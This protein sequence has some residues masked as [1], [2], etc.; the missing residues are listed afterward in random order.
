MLNGARRAA[1][2]SDNPLIVNG[3][4][5]LANMELAQNKVKWADS[6]SRLIN[7]YGQ[8]VERSR[9]L[10]ADELKVNPYRFRQ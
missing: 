4:Q 5:T 6:E 8:I 2:T 7:E 10:F 1:S 9:Q 3:Q